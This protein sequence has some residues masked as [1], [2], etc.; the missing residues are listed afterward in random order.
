VV[1]QD[2]VVAK[3]RPS[4]VPIGQT[5]RRD[6]I[7]E[8]P[9]WDFFVVKERYNPFTH[10]RETL[11]YTTFYSL[12]PEALAMLRVAFKRW[13]DEDLDLRDA[14]RWAGAYSESLHSLLNADWTAGRLPD[15]GGFVITVRFVDGS[16]AETR[17]LAGEPDDEALTVDLYLTTTHLLPAQ[18][19]NDRAALTA[20]AQQVGLMK[21][22]TLMS[23]RVRLHAPPAED[24]DER[25]WLVFATGLNPWA[26][27]VGPRDPVLVGESLVA[28]SRLLR[29]ADMAELIALR[30]DVQLMR[31]AGMIELNT[32]EPTFVIYDH[33]RP[34]P[35]TLVPPPPTLDDVANAEAK[36]IRGYSRLAQAAVLPTVLDAVSAE[37]LGEALRDPR[38]ANQIAHV[39]SLEQQVVGLAALYA[40]AGLPDIANYSAEQVLQWRDSLAES[41]GAFH[42]RVRNLLIDSTVGPGASDL[43]EY[44]RLIGPQLD[45]D[46]YEIRCQSRS[47]RLW[48]TTKERFPV[49]VGL[50]S[51]LALEL[52]WAGQPLLAASAFLQGTAAQALV[53][54]AEAVRRSRGTHRHPLYW[55]HVVSAT[56]V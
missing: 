27:L 12:D 40:V 11:A 16:F 46:L 29:P 1:R 6:A 33:P 38:H 50:G 19:E 9:E 44:M 5:L 10:G 23:Q 51:S 28:E 13:T 22:A 2:D 45:R 41:L 47:A 25:S 7:G 37:A 15:Q 48:D 17:V 8:R 20:V 55:R 14:L 35:K 26:W 21:A 56:E 34:R 49:M 54:V 31:G 3:V 53:N 39:S 36:R 43:P 52:M 32:S 30:T 4:V 42:E 24:D 18:V